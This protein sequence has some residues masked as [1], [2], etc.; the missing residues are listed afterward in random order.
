MSEDCGTSGE[1][2]QE[3]LLSVRGCC[4]SP[5]HV[6]LVS[7]DSDV[8]LRF[9]L[10]CLHRLELG[11]GLEQSTIE[12]NESIVVVVSSLFF[13]LCFFCFG[14]EPVE[15]L[16]V[17]QLLCCCCFSD[18]GGGDS[19]DDASIVIFSDSVSFNGRFWLLLW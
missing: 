12:E 11:L 8:D 7:F 17:I 15:N 18:G 2:S 10:T 13:I 1:A 19:D 14:L 16:V 3:E 5:S 6:S 9:L 4:S